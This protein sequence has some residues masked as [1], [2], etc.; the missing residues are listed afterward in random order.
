M[1][2]NDLTL[3]GVILGAVGSGLWI[4]ASL[5]SGD[6]GALA[7]TY[8]NA[9][10][11]LFK[12]QLLSRWEARFSGISL[13]AGFV[14]SA[15]GTIQASIGQNEAHRFADKWESLFFL[16]AGGV[17]VGIAAGAIARNRGREEF[18]R[19]DAPRAIEQLE[20]YIRWNAREGYAPE[21]GVTT[22]DQA[23]ERLRYM[24]NAIPEIGRQLEMRYCAGESN[25]AY[26]ERMIRELR[27][28]SQ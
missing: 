8:C 6:L 2:G 4:K 18:R 13:L 14:C 16:G 19:W 27:P 11:Y 23:L 15:G 10:P 25:I 26:A 9:N 12:A 24:E 22:P 1:S 3:I 17:F 20:R 28:Y 21:E 7:A 5:W